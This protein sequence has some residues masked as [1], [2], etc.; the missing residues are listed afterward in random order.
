MVIVNNY[1]VRTYDG[2][3]WFTLMKLG[4]FGGDNSLLAYA[5]AGV[6]FFLILFG[7]MFCAYNTDN[8]IEQELNKKNSNYAVK[9][10]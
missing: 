10:K 9:F 8:M 1:D 6:A 2:A 5:Y 7:L 4:Q 3:K